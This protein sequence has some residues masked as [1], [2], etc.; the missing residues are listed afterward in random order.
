MSKQQIDEE[1]LQWWERD[2]EE[3]G[4]NMG[5]KQVMVLIHPTDIFQM[6]YSYHEFFNAIRRQEYG[7]LL[8]Y[9]FAYRLCRQSLLETVAQDEAKIIPFPRRK[10]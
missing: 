7:P 2:L 4:Y 3:K 6:V 1:F 8:A 5:K 10:R 9:N